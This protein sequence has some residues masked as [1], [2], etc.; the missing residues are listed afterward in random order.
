MW[1]L[2][3]DLKYKDWLHRTNNEYRNKLS[4]IKTE[5]DKLK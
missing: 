1:H 2:S 3:N 5:E 4:D